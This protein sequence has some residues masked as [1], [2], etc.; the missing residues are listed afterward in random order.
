MW[1]NADLTTRRFQHI[2]DFARNSSVIDANIGGF[3]IYMDGDAFTVSGS[4]FG[5]LKNFK[6][7]IATELLRGLPTATTSR[8][9]SLSWIDFLKTLAGDDENTNILTTPTIY[10]A[11]DNFFAK[12]LTVPEDSPLTTTA[13]QSYFGYMMSS[14]VPQSWFSILNLYGGPG[15]AINS[16]DVGFSAYSDRSSLW[17]FQHYVYT[18]VTATLSARDMSWIEGLGLALTTKMPGVQFGGYLNYVDPSLTAAEAHQ[19][20]YGDSLYQK[21][22]GIKNQVDPSSVFW[23]PQ[24]IGAQ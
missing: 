1:D 16:R 21:L 3:E 7:M 19:F 8:V 14:S 12:S 11:H 10:D 15:S 18:D 24:A 2:Q 6:N 17:V 5:T 9:E 4:Y 23:N 22:L 13:L 20:Y